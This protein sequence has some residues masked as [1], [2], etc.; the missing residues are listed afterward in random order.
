MALSFIKDAH[1]DAETLSNSSNLSNACKEMPLLICL[2][3]ILIIICERMV[4]DT[5]IWVDCVYY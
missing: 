3:T 4:S 5:M 1:Y 2:N